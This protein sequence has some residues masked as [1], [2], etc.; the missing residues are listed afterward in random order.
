MSS[1]AQIVRKMSGGVKG[2]R[3]K[4]AELNKIVK[5]SKR[6][7]GI[8]YPV[9]N[10]RSISIDYYNQKSNKD[11]AKNVDRSMNSYIQGNYNIFDISNRTNLM[12][13]GK[14]CKEY[15]S[16]LMTCDNKTMEYETTRKSLALNPDGTM[17]GV[18]IV[19]RWKNYYSII[20]DGG[21]SDTL[22]EHFFDHKV[23]F[24]ISLSNN[25]VDNLYLFKGP[26]SLWAVEQVMHYLNNNQNKGCKVLSSLNYQRN[27]NFANQLTPNNSFSV[28]NTPQGYIVSINKQISDRVFSNL[29][30]CVSSSKDYETNR[31]EAG[32]PCFTR[33]LQGNYNPI[34]A[35]LHSHFSKNYKY[36]KRGCLGSSFLG[37]NPLFSENGTFKRFPRTRVMLYSCDKGLI[38]PENSSIYSNGVKVGTVTSAAS[39]SYLKCIVAMGYVN[40]EKTF[41]TRSFSLAREIVKKVEISGNSYFIKFL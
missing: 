17:L 2:I 16:F 41:K 10:R 32:Q 6:G 34:E 20:M 40:L 39:S 35:N 12:V 19:N 11:K 13:S 36:S 8:P 7:Y 28:I 33:D 22:L 9:I 38:P 31:V 18:G 1:A 21:K 24:D 3:Y 15:V 29:N 27:I 5:P 37:K 25:L 4:P 26:A 30:M 23:G 14:D